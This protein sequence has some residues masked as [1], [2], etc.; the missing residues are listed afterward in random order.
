MQ[1]PKS[2]DVLGTVNRGDPAESSLCTLCR[3]D[4][5]GKCETFLS[6]LMGRKLLYPRDFG[7]VTAGADNINHVGVSY[8]SLRIQGYA[9]GAK[10]IHSQMTSDPDDCIFTNADISSEFG[11]EIPTKTS[12][13][14]WN[15]SSRAVLAKPGYIWLCS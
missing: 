15:P 1:I 3:S 7:T 4:C 6:S 9:Y 14:S 11:A 10:G 8:K 5:K 2:N 13:I 12:A